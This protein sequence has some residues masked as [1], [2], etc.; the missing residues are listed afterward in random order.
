M[1]KQPPPIAVFRH[2]VVLSAGIR[3][4]SSGAAL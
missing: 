2:G 1:T 3:A 4:A